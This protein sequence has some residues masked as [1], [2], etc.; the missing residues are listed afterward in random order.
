VLEEAS[1]VGE[2]KDLE[3]NVLKVTPVKASA[4]AASTRIAGRAELWHRRYNHLGLASLK[5]AGTIVYGMPLSVVDAKRVIGTA[6][7]PC[8]DGQTV[9]AP[10][11]RSSTV[12]TKCKLVHT[13]GRH[14]YIPEDYIRA[15]YPYSLWIRAEDVYPKCSMRKGEEDISI[16]SDRNCKIISDP[17]PRYKSQDIA[18]P[19]IL[20]SSTRNGFWRY[21]SCGTGH[22]LVERSGKQLLSTNMRRPIGSPTATSVQNQDPSFS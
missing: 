12:K 1:V 8:V 22:L 16:L 6:C 21:G 15:L 13:R 14:G 3:Q 9:Q 19:P 17:S 11:P 7:V 2:V 20:S 4:C 5:L 10:S 18:H